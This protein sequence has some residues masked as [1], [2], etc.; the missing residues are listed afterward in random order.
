MNGSTNGGVVGFNSNQADRMLFGVES[1]Q[2]HSINY[3]RSCFWELS[4]LI[5][6]DINVSGSK[7]TYGWHSPE[8]V[9]FEKNVFQK[10][11]EDLWKRTLRLYSEI[12]SKVENSIKLW[13][14]TT[15]ET[16]RVHALEAPHEMNFDEYPH[17]TATDRSGN[18]CINPALPAAI[19]AHRSEVIK[20]YEWDI[21][22]IMK[23]LSIPVYLGANQQQAFQANAK[24][25]LE[26]L[27]DEIYN[28]HTLAADEIQKAADKYQRIAR[29]VAN[30][31][32]NGN[33]TN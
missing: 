22:T 29:Q 13:A 8:A 30:S 23:D 20:V 10:T 18:I 4:N 16:Y 32:N 25:L 3:I 19:R 33:I 24:H 1:A 9:T 7:G 26:T 17:A 27:R 2:M 6:H 31:F 14:Q 21:N 11:Y 12:Y 5:F 15:G 28:L